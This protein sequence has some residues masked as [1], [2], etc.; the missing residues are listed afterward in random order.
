M[1]YPTNAE[2]LATVEENPDWLQDLLDEDMDGL[3]DDGLGDCVT[4]AI[5]LGPPDLWCVVYVYVPLPD[6]CGTVLYI[7][8]WE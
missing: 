6:W 1:T 5:C 3:F 2:L 4:D 7:F 8:R